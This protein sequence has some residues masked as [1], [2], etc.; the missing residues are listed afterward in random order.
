MTTDNRQ[1]R[2]ALGRF[3]TGVTIVTTRAA[4]GRP[5]GMTVNS[6]ASVSLEPPLVSWCLDEITPGF[7]VYL[8]SP[9]FAVQV[10]STEQVA[11]AV[12]FA[13]DGADK[14]ADIAWTSGLYDLPLLADT[15]V[16][17]QCLT[18]H[19]ISAGDHRILIGEV[20]TFEHRPGTPL[21][22]VD[23]RFAAPVA[24]DSAD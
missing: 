15:L 3:A 4:D 24:L 23:G 5:L 13:D 17:F 12:R 14:F 9:G 8:D 21:I 20:L 22:F 19:R 16:C 11:L 10:L 2:N 6:F 1:L 18:R 7:E